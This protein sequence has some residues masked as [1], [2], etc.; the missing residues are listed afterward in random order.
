MLATLLETARRKTVRIW[1][2]QSPFDIRG[3]LKKRGYRWNAGEDGRPRAWFIDV[4][5]EKRDDEIAY[6][7]SSIYLRDV[8]LLMQTITALDR[9]SVCG[10]RCLSRYAPRRARRK[11]TQHIELGAPSA[12]AC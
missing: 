7:R 9:F 4:D 12:M 2:E 10:Y 1:A 3:E 5:E 11:Y 6:L 8:D